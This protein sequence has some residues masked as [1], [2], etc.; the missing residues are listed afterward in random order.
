MYMY[1]HLIHNI[2]YN[3]ICSIIYDQEALQFPEPG[4]LQEANCGETLASPLVGRVKDTYMLL[5]FLESTGTPQ[6]KWYIS[7]WFLPVGS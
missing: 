4:S 6:P 7:S 1:L 3:Q 2:L 5:G